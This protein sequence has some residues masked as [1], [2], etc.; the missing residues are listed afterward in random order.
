MLQLLACLYRRVPSMFDE[1]GFQVTLEFKGAYITISREF[2]HD[3]DN[4]GLLDEADRWIK[5]NRGK[6]P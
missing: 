6:W 4:G 2:W 3:D 5:K 1:L